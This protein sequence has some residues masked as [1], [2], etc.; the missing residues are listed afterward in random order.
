M[1]YPRLPASGMPI[2]YRACNQPR[3]ETSAVM[4]QIEPLT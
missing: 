4:Q 2:T 3:P 1:Y